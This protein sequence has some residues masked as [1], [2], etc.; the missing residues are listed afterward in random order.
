VYYDGI[1]GIRSVGSLL[2]CTKST[3]FPER[4]L[5][6]PQF[7][8]EALERGSRL[9]S[10]EI[11]GD[12]K[13]AEGL[14]RR[15]GFVT[16]AGHAYSAFIG[17][18]NEQSIDVPI[19]STSAWFTSTEGFNEHVA[20]ELMEQGNTV[21]FVGSEGS[22]H[23][24][25]D[26][27]GSFSDIS[28]ARSAAAVLRFSQ[29]APGLVDKQIQV[30]EKDRFLNGDSR[31]A[32]VAMGMMAFDSYFGQNI[33]YGDVTAAC[34]PQR[35]NLLKDKRKLLKFVAQEPVMLAILIAPM[36]VRKR[37]E[38]LSTIDLHPASFVHQLAITGA[39]FSGE[40]GDL[41]QH[42]PTDKV[43][44]VLVYRGD[45]VSM[46]VEWD[47]IFVDHDEVRITGVGGS[48]LT[49]ADPNTLAFQ[50]ARN[51]AVREQYTQGMQ[52]SVAKVSVRAHEVV[53]NYRTKDCPTSDMALVS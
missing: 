5:Q 4:G 6:N 24:A 41:A 43:A 40:A 10:L 35:F 11:I 12:V 51:Q 26:C 32:M 36:P 30:S 29:E 20:R 38:L 2:T 19:V 42:I 45:D 8:L 25:F 3:V 49:I 48:H 13:K 17:I 39:I 50:L 7:D 9:K 16:L 18:P 21:F 46:H 27:G 31:G 14:I 1:M 52:M 37:I 22:Y 28:L 34:F 44:H 15:V 33:V 53:D 23:G 47:K